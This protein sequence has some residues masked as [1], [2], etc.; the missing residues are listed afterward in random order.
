MKG[1]PLKN[2]Q[3]KY[4]TCRHPTVMSH[5]F[6]DYFQTCDMPMDIMFTVGAAVCGMPGQ[7]YKNAV[8]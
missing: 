5:I 1:G 2:G 8:S 4:R 6:Y 7:C 3:P